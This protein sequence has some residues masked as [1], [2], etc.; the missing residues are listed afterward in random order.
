V[1][2][3]R[4]LVGGF[5]GLGLLLAIAAGLIL[6]SPARAVAGQAVACEG[7]V[8]VSGNVWIDFNTTPPAYIGDTALLPYFS[9]DKPGGSTADKWKAI[10]NLGDQKLLVKDGATITVVDVPATSNNRRSPGIVVYACALTIEGDTDHNGTPG[11][12]L[13][14]SVNQAAG[15]ILI[16]VQADIKVGGNI[17]NEV[18]GTNGTPGNITLVSCSGNITVDSTG[19]IET[20]GIDPG[21]SDINILTCCVTDEGNIVINGLVDASYR[22]AKASTINIVSFGGKVTIDGNNLLYVE[23]GTQRPVTSG[24]TVRSRRDP[25]G[26]T[27]NIQA[28]SDITVYGNTILDPA[29][30]NLGAVAG[31]KMATSGQGN[32]GDLNVVSLEGRILASDRAFDFA[33]RFNQLATIDLS[34]KGDIKL[35]SNQNYWIPVVST[36]D[37]SDGKG[38][39]NTLRSYSESILIGIN[40]QVL[41]D[42]MTDGVN[43]LT[44]CK[45]V[46]NAGTV[47]PADLVPGDDS[48]VCS[49]EAPEPLFENCADF[50]KYGVTQCPCGPPPTCPTCDDPMQIVVV[51]QN[52]TVDLNPATPTYVGDPDLQPYFSW[53]KSGPTVDTWKAIFD[54][55]TK[56]LLVKKGATITVAQ[57]PGEGGSTNRRSPGIVILSTCE[58]EIEDGGAVVVQSQNKP[59]G[60]IFIRVDG[61]VKIDG[62]VRDEVTGTNGMPGDITIVTKCKDINVGPTG[63]ILDLGVDPGGRDINLVTTC[64]GDIVVNGLVMAYAHAHGADQS[65]ATRPD[66]RVVAYNGSVTIN[67]N[68]LEP[69]LDESSFP[70]GSTRYDLFGGLLSWVR[71]NNA[72]GSIKVQALNDITVKGHGNDP[73][74]PVKT[75]FAA[76][77][78]VAGSSTPQGGTID[79]RSLEGSIFGNDRAFQVYRGG[80]NAL[81]RL[82]AEA[83]VTLNRPG[84]NDTFNPV[85]DVKYGPG[86]TRGGTNDVRAFSGGITVGPNAQVL[87]NGST[88]ANNGTNNFTYCTT[89]T[90]NGTVNPA[91]VVKQDCTPPA[92]EALFTNWLIDFLIQLVC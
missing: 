53:D 40:A 61:T 69:L 44:S 46:S 91:P 33:N 52:V 7:E 16:Q 11:R 37:G 42:G 24:V 12:I 73:T 38:G 17:R 77:A 29:H 19:V 66:I 18:V 14:D 51:D 34:A 79:V 88:V 3:K 8:V 25:L 82:W 47:D 30:P 63:R 4:V 68:S 58:L 60:D 92:P 65:E 83:N 13:V 75:S 45:G 55:G 9:W 2:K 64:D 6:Y 70:I 22:G 26:G 1:S 71:D 15:D 5:L 62:T 81:I 59:A 76:I 36:R 32:G 31:N 72:P 10:F 48:G 56:K 20:I 78:V 43:L 50:A 41:A 21:G 80:I 90:N 35:S 74:P 54:V 49:P 84:A 57:G 23:A 39:T 27:I 67:A 85:V 28:M 89:L 87:A 86:G